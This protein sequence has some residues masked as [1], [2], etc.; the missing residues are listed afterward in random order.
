MAFTG[1][2][3]R[4]GLLLKEHSLRTCGFKNVKGRHK[5]VWNVIIVNVQAARAVAR[6]GIY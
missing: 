6:I 2:Q 3:I 1:S 5:T 4:Y